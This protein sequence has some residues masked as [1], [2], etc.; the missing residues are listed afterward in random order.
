MKT[1]N[2][3][4][5]IVFLTNLKLLYL[6]FFLL[7]MPRL[8]GI[9]TDEIKTDNFLSNE[10]KIRLIKESIL[11]NQDVFENYVDL[12]AVFSEIS[13]FMNL[14]RNVT[15]ETIEMEHT[16]RKLVEQK[17][18]DE[19]SAKQQFEKEAEEK[20]PL[21]NIGDEVKVLYLLSGKSFCASG[22]FYRINQDCVWIGSKQILRKTL[23]EV[24][25]INLFPEKN[26][27]TR[28][29]YIKEK[30]KAYRHLC[31][32]YEQELTEIEY[33]K[34]SGKLF[35]GGKWMT[36]RNLIISR[37]KFINEEGEIERI[38][39]DVID[40]KD[41][42]NKIAH[43]KHILR[44]IKLRFPDHVERIM[45]YQK[46]LKSDIKLH[47]EELVAQAKSMKDSRE[48]IVFLDYLISTYPN[49]ENIGLAKEALR[50][51]RENIK[52]KNQDALQKTTPLSL[53][54]I[55]NRSVTRKK[56][57]SKEYNQRR[58]GRIRIYVRNQSDRSNRNKRRNRSNQR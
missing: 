36:P 37:V 31:S 26:F 50:V 28:D 23:S 29:K 13:N 52:N 16:R 19:V 27:E 47:I 57:K 3:K 33:E 43:L 6:L 20:F 54:R 4:A 38:S 55:T 34:K 35:F 9:E 44:I 32:A 42:K 46:L 51:A 49:A 8:T 45:E 24:S 15:K 7:W 10:E 48:S 18:S 58:S 5:V 14:D 17:F 11:K 22:I 21:F 39:H 30:M 1:C 56:T 40:K 53:P 12:N 2:E 41:L 25:Y